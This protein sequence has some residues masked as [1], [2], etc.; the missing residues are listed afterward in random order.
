V[1]HPESGA[2]FNNLAQTLADQKKWPEAR[3]AAQQAVERSGP[4]LDTFRETLKQIEAQ[5]LETAAPQE[6]EDGK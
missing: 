3:A 1:D 2:A 5:L 6:M 4:Q